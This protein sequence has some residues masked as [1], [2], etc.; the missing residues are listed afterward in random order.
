V[1]FE[2]KDTERH[3]PGTR[4]GF[5]AQDVEKVMPTWVRTT[6][7]GTKALNTGEFDALLVES[8]RTLKTENDALRA[9]LDKIESKSKLAE[10]SML[11][12]PIG[13]AGLALVG[14][15]VIKR[16]RRSDH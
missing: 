12:G 2:W 15:M 13:F 10:A 9:R 8:V 1:T 4:R 5:I 3:F 6:F 14:A 7:K 16:R 11:G